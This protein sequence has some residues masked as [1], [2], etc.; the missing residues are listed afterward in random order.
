MRWKM[1][2]FSPVQIASATRSCVMS[3]FAPG[4]DQRPGKGKLILKR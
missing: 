4:L 3:A 2:P 1:F